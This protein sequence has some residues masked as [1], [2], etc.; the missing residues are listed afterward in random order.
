MLGVGKKI[1]NEHKIKI[2]ERNAFA[3]RKKYQIEIDLKVVPTKNLKYIEVW[4]PLPRNTSYQKVDG[5]RIYPSEQEILKDEFFGNFVAHWKTESSVNGGELLFNQKSTV[6]VEPREA[7]VTGSLEDFDKKD[8][9]YQLYTKEDPYFNFGGSRVKDLAEKIIGKEKELAGITES[10]YSYVRDHFHYGSPIEGLY[11][12]IEAM[13]KKQVDCGGFDSLLGALYRV[14]GVPARLISGFLAGY[15][16][17]HYHAWLEF[18]VPDGNWVPV[19]PSVENLRLS[20]RD[21]KPGGFGRVG[22]DRIVVSIGSA[23]SMN[24]KKFPLLQLPQVDAQ[25]GSGVLVSRNIKIIQV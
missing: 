5:S 12:S 23:I 6:L 8:P 25:P 17:E 11:N 16:G 7:K 18:M 1:I 3:G 21:F 2:A 20:G 4:Q 24:G 9:I 19:D 10:L 13:E 14:V 22:N 15:E